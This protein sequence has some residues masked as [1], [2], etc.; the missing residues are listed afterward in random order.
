MTLESD[1]SSAPP[2]AACDSRRNFILQQGLCDP[3]A[4]SSPRLYSALLFQP[5]VIAVW[6]ILATI[7]QSRYAFFALGAL[8][9]WNVLLPRFNPFDAIYNAIFGRRS[10]MMLEP[11]PVPRRFAQSIAGS[12]A[13]AIGLALTFGWRTTAYV[14]EGFL[15]LALAMLILAG[16]CLGSFIY[17]LVRGKLNFACKT[18]PWANGV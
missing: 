10:G 4:G 16:F 14:L 17:H 13:L 11:A 15:F 9:W 3:A 5:R 1:P 12:F 18:L 2:V 8:L 7:F 6:A